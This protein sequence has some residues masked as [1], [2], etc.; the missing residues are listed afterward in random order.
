MVHSI[1]LPLVD[2]SREKATHTRIIKVL[3]P[4]TVD[5]DIEELGSPP[6]EVVKEY[7]PVSP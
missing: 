4:R 5:E 6:I 2:Q 7:S 1:A 3:P